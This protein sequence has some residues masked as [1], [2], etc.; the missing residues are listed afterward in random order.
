[1]RTGFVTHL[2]CALTGARQAAGV[3]ANLS[4]A[5]KPLLVR[6]DLPAIA[7]AVRREDLQARA[8]SLWRFREFLPVRHDENIVSLGEQVT[9]LIPAPEIA[10]RSGATGA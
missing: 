7:W 9:P 8:P 3:V 5:G 4:A 1:M 6:Y 2:E 10:R